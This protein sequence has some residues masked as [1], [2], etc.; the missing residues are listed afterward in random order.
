MAEFM[1]EC[2][3]A[4]NGL[5]IV[6]AAVQLIEHGKMVDIRVIA[7]RRERAITTP[8]VILSGFKGP[9]A[10]PDGFRMVCSGL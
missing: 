10:R 3:N 8:R 7:C 9:V 4:V 5:A 6:I 1:N 2:A